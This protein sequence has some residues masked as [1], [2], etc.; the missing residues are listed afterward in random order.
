MIIQYMRSSSYNNWDFCQMQYYLTYVL[1]YRY[2]SVQKAE[3]G[4]IVHKV[5]ECLAVI[6][7]ELQQNPKTNKINDEQLGVIKFN[8]KNFVKSSFLKPSEIAKVNLSRKAK[9]TY[10]SACTVEQGHMRRGV[11]IVEDIFERSFTYYKDKSIH[12]WQPAH[13][14]DCHNFTWMALD[15]KNGMLDPRLRT[16]VDAEPKFDIVIDRPW[17]KYEFTTA[18]GDKKTGNLAIKGTIDLITEVAPRILE[19]VDWKTGLRVDWGAKGRVM[20]VK[21]Y[22]KLCEDPQLMLYYLAARHMYPDAEAII[23]SI[24]YVRDGGPF[25]LS[26]DDDT[27]SKMEGLLEQRFNE[28]RSCEQPKL[29]DPSQKHFKCAYLCPFSKNYFEGHESKNMCHHADREIQLHG[30]E[31]V[32]KTYKK[33]GHST[34][35]YDAPGE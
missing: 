17:A 15:F 34:E 13:R 23:L 3:Q 30:L 14:R 4:T 18:E 19:I 32:R 33:E 28:I 29:L 26:F 22:E 27:V 10:K 2:P 12:H 21:T 1:G 9:T 24:F 31:H 6:K 7:K 11:G 5:L 20:P 8:P 16:I 35:V 25:S